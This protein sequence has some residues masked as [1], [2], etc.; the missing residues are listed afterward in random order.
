MDIL[1]LNSYF[2]G[3]HENSVNGDGNA[4]DE[5]YMVNSFVVNSNYGENPRI[6]W[7]GFVGNIETG[8]PHDLHGRIDG[9]LQVL[10]PQI[11]VVVASW[12][13]VSTPSEKYESQLG[14]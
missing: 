7:I 11:V 3:Y 14:L 6:Q 13:V 4:N 5:W 8:K 1:I 10:I 12:L 2:H 9:F